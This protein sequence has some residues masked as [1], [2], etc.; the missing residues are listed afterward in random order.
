MTG[1]ME[2][3]ARD[4]P[5]NIAPGASE[6]PLD[7]GV[8]SCRCRTWR[9]GSSLRRDDPKPA[10]TIYLARKASRVA[11]MTGRAPIDRPD[12]EFTTPTCSGSPVGAAPWRLGAD[13]GLACRARK[14]ATDGPV[15]WPRCCHHRAPPQR[16]EVPDRPAAQVRRLPLPLA[17]GGLR[18]GDPS[19]GAGGHFVGDGRGVID[20]QQRRRVPGGATSAGRLEGQQKLGQAV[21]C[22]FEKMPPAPCA[23]PPRAGSVSG[24]HVIAARR[25]GPPGPAH[26][27][28]AAAGQHMALQCC[29]HDYAA[30]CP[31]D[32]GALPVT[33]HNTYCQA[34]RYR[35]AQVERLR[36]AL[37]PGS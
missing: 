24:Q 10:A 9:R 4:Q 37:L 34:D 12:T 29:Q 3:V 35:F 22:P 32:T 20:A 15:R 33:G 23:S 18:R 5:P 31:S 11:S 19:R 14:S 25:R 36:A 21:L 16:P 28:R 17:L 8:M 26:Q 1:R 6:Q 27:G 2:A 30:H 13:C 7:L